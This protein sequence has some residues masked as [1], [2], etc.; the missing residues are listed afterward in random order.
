M[1]LVRVPVGGE[2]AAGVVGLSVEEVGEGMK[3]QDG[4]DIAR[5]EQVRDQCLDEAMKN[6]VPGYEHI[7]QS[8]IVSAGIAQDK[9]SALRRAK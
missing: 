3:K 9:I 8:Y 4:P 2:D 5:W 7:T 6:M 1:P